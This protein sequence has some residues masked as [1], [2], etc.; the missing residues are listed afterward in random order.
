[1]VAYAKHTVDLGKGDEIIYVFAPPLE[2]LSDVFAVDVRAYGELLRTSMSEVLDYECD[3]AYFSG[4]GYEFSIYR[5]TTCIDRLSR[6][7]DALLE[8]D[9]SRLYRLI[10]NYLEDNQ[11]PIEIAEW[12]RDD[13]EDD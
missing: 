3:S 12:E 6:D 10:G 11:R 1:M 2:S 7:E 9:T 4:T 5:D 13:G 8:M